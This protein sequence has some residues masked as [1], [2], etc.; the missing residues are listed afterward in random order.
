MRGKDVDVDKE[1]LLLR[2]STSYADIWREL[3]T[4]V[5]GKEYKKPVNHADF[6]LTLSINRRIFEDLGCAEASDDQFSVRESNWETVKVALLTRDDA[7]L[8]LDLRKPS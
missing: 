7:L 6:F 2:P 5:A 8:Y 1:L 3:R 4:L